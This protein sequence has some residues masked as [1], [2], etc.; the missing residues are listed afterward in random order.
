L[1]AVDLSGFQDV[2]ARVGDHRDQFRSQ[3]IHVDQFRG[4]AVDPYMATIGQAMLGELA[5][6]DD[7]RVL[8]FGC[9]SGV[10]T[11]LMSFLPNVRSV[12]GIDIDAQSMAFA[13]QY[14]APLSDRIDF[15]QGRSHR[16]PIIWRRFDLIVVNQV[17]CNMYR[18]EYETMVK[19]LCRLLKRRGRIVLVDSNNPNNPDVQARL[20]NLY[21]ILEN[22]ETGS[23]VK[24]RENLVAKLDPGLPAREIALRTCYFDR[25]EIEAAVRRLRETGE[26]PE[27]RFEPDTLRVP[28]ALGVGAPSGPTDPSW[29][30]EEF[31]RHGIECVAGH[32]YPVGEGMTA[33]QLAAAGSFYLVRVLP[34]ETRMDRFLAA[35][36]R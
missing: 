31:R 35:F 10:T 33:E 23:G 25:A 9:W 22:P 17:F 4:A 5:H 13:K 16:L 15:V 14:L 1:P 12:T 32:A 34:P 3:A 26:M 2:L 36:G 21:T 30:I 8:D 28:R 6:L 7:A 20:K 18:G 27:S 19:E 24:A 29:F 11:L